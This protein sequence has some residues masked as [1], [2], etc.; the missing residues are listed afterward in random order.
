MYYIFETVE[1]HV[2]VSICPTSTPPRVRPSFPSRRGRHDDD[3][4][5][6]DGRNRRRARERAN[7]R[8]SRGGERERERERDAL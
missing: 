7:E 5:D 1:A 6:D 2:F 8:E 3:D 4:D